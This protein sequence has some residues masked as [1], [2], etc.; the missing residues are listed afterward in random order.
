MGIAATR[1]ERSGFCLEG[2][3]ERRTAIHV[4]RYWY[5][6]CKLRSL[7][8]PFYLIYSTSLDHPDEDT[9]LDSSRSK[10]DE[11]GSI[12]VRVFLVE[13]QR[14][15]AG[16]TGRYRIKDHPPASIHEQAKKAG[17]HCTS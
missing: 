5:D 3:S 2:F 12:S 13:D 6:R 7:S 10:P 15:S 11:I 8:Q 16:S 14:L 1:Y 17:Q 4:R 9:V